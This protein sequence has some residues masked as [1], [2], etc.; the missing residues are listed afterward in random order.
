MARWSSVPAAGSSK[1]PGHRPRVVPVTAILLLALVGPLS[2]TP[3]RAAKYAG[4]FLRIGAGARALGMGGAVTALIDDASAIYWNPAGIVAIP[5]AEILLM[6]AEQFGNLV[7]YDFGGYVQSLEGTGTPGAVGIGLVRFAVSDI[8][9]T[10][11]AYQDLNGNNR[12]DHGVDLILEE[13]FYLDSDTELGLFFT[14]ARPVGERLSLGGS[15]KV[16]RQDLVNHGSFGIGADLGALWRPGGDFM[17]GARFSDITTTQL[18]WDTGR[19]ETVTPAL[20]LG[21]AWKRSLASASLDV[22][23]AADLAFTFEGREAASSFSAGAIGG[24]VHLGTEIW[25]RK[26]FAGRLGYQETGVTGG[27]GFRIKGFGVDYAYV[28]HDELGS[29]HRVSASYRF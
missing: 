3:V 14:Y 19:R 29:S 17:L 10:K 11:N 22:T 8:L 5:R 20:F 12:Y 18:W 9:V 13:Q 1:R 16:V 6:H 28:P 26:L 7:D 21:G 23:L 24:D 25:F 27:A 15:L 2:S 4:E